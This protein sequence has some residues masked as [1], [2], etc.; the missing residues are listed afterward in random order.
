LPGNECRNRLFRK[1]FALFG[2]RTSK[3]TLA[4]IAVEGRKSA[5]KSRRLPNYY[6]IV[7]D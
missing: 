4:E 6:A 2:E 7:L 5:E 1:G 3:V